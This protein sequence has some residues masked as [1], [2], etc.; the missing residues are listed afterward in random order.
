MI[1]AMTTV[2][3]NIT[4]PIETAEAVRAAAAGERSISAYVSDILAEHIERTERPA[5]N[6]QAYLAEHFAPFTPETE[7]FLDGELARIE[8]Q[9]HNS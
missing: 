7:A 1:I 4:V 9:R 5:F 6:V 3:L 8:H 2:K